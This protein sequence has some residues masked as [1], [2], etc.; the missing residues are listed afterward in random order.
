MVLLQTLL[1][2]M[3]SQDLISFLMSTPGVGPPATP[4]VPC[5]ACCLDDASFKRLLRNAELACK[6]STVADTGM[7]GWQPA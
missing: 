3:F 4:E 2:Y 5:C 7:P 1:F 6:V